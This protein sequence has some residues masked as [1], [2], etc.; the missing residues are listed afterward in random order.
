MPSQIIPDPDQPG[1]NMGVS[2]EPEPP[3][4]LVE[5]QATCLTCIGEYQMAKKDKEAGILH[6]GEVPIIP[7]VNVA[8]TLAPTWQQTQ[9][10][11]QMVMACVTVPTC[12]THLSTE[13]K[14]AIERATASGLA[15]GGSN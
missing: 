12:L 5:M 7:E 4:G 1:Y 11:G 8:V 13:K 15:I 10:M 6:D 2:W 14:S 3:R 9:V